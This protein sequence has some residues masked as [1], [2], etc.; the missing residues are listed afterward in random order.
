M[1]CY[2]LL[3]VVPVHSFVY[4]KRKEPDIVAQSTGCMLID[5]CSTVQRV[6]GAGT[7]S[8][9]STNWWTLWVADR[10]KS[11]FHRLDWSVRRRKEWSSHVES[12]QWRV[13]L[14]VLRYHWPSNFWVYWS[15]C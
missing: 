11:L 2:I 3:Y 9:Y 8:V 1:D 10:V 4:N 7:T 5:I 14:I 6:C 13:N 12:R 15:Y